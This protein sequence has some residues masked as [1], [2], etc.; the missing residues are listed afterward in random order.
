M[1]LALYFI[2]NAFLAGRAYEI[3]SARPNL[4]DP[5]LHKYILTVLAFLFGLPVALGIVIIEAILKLKK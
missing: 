5:I 1:I 3:E 2:C 4:N